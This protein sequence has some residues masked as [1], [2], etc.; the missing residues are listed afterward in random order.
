MGR[1]PFA[2]ERSAALVRTSI[3]WTD[4]RLESQ[5]EIMEN[6]V[7][8]RS[9]RSLLGLLGVLA[10]SP[11]RSRAEAWWR[12]LDATAFPQANGDDRHWAK[13]PVVPNKIKDRIEPLEYSSQWLDPDSFLG[14]RVGLNLQVGLLKAVDVDSY[15]LPYREGKRPFWPSGEYRGCTFIRAMPSCARSCS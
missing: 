6:L 14:R 10:V 7:T 1:E 2:A 4:D 13:Q 9:R 3:L 12:T 5:E 15:L 8:R 11:K